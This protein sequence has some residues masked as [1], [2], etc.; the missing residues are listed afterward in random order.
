M[1][2]IISYYLQRSVLLLN[3]CIS[4][5]HA[6]HERAVGSKQRRAGQHLRARDACEMATNASPADLRERERASRRVQASCLIVCFICSGVLFKQRL[7]TRSLILARAASTSC[8]DPKLKR[9]ARKLPSAAPLSSCW[10][11]SLYSDASCQRARATDAPPGV[12][13]G[14]QTSA[15]GLEPRRASTRGVSTLLAAR[16]CCCHDRTLDSLSASSS[17]KYAAAGQCTA[18]ASPA[19]GRAIPRRCSSATCSSAAS[20]FHVCACSQAALTCRWRSDPQ[21]A[22][23]SAL[24]DTMSAPLP[25]SSRVLQVVC[26]CVCLCVVGRATATGTDAFSFS[27][28]NNKR[29]IK[30][31]G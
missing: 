21:A 4:C 6:E 7:S 28:R 5:S 16:A 22:H 18:V 14:A 10:I 11:L 26:V 19:P 3:V 13:R 25:A 1:Q 29:Q 17:C 2:W 30:I 12:R 8:S 23:A 20:C 9:S 24:L 27:W 15:R 31:S